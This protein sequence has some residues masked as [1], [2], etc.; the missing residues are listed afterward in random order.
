MSAQN[1]ADSTSVVSHLVKMS[2]YLSNMASEIADLKSHV[3]TP[4]DISPVKSVVEEDTTADPVVMC[5]EAINAK[6]SN[7]KALIEKYKSALTSEKTE[8]VLQ[9]K[10]AMED[11]KTLKEEMS[12]LHSALQMLTT[13]HEV[14]PSKIVDTKAA[15][16]IAD[17]KA[18][19]KIADIK[20]AD[21]KTADI[22]TVSKDVSFAASLGVQLEDK[23]SGHV[24]VAAAAASSD[25]SA[26]GVCEYK[27]GVPVYTR[28][29]LKSC[30]KNMFLDVIT[31]RVH[32]E[33]K[34]ATPKNMC[35]SNETLAK[36]GIYPAYTCE[37]GIGV[38][39]PF[40]RFYVKERH[41]V[42]EILGMRFFYNEKYEVLLDAVL[43]EISQK[44]FVGKNQDGTVGEYEVVFKN[45]TNVKKYADGKSHT[46]W[47][48]DA[49]YFDH[50]PEVS[51][52]DDDDDGV[53]D[54]AE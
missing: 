34:F 21:I 35:F 28:S 29:G 48:V 22:K 38:N 47:Q 11:L 17:T 54:V 39:V 50:V 19:V 16:K 23:T 46:W 15:V 43:Y 49:E 51:H 5:Q 13:T 2:G 7:L 12:V 26:H 33:D 41:E 44:V 27:D 24:P 3:K 8:L 31:E 9:M 20:V 10:S 40:S 53:D 4:V 18:A 36:H 32:L 14:A 25:D 37:G 30:M 52:D 42:E 1:T 45:K 6:T